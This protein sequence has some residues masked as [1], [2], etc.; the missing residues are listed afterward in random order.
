MNALIYP[1]SSYRELCCARRILV[2]TTAS[3]TFPSR[4]VRRY[5]GLLDLINQVFQE[6]GPKGFFKGLTPSLLK[7]SFS[8]GFMFFW[9][10]FFC[11]LFHCIRRQDR[12]L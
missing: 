3:Y 12:E 11:N 10:E 9:Y 8:T 7:A 1:V 2:L 4:Q 6:E 5:E